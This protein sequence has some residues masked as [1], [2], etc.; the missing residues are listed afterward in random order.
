[1]TPASRAATHDDLAAAVETI[2]TSFHHDP[3]WAWA[4]PDPERRAGQYRV[5]WGLLLEGG[6][7]YDWVRVTERCESVAVWIPPGGTELAPEDEPRVAPL[8]TSL[9]DDHAPAV[10]EL[11]ERFEAAHPRDE[12]HYYL[13]LFGTHDDHRGKGLGMALLRENLALIDAEGMPAYLESTNPV[14]LERYRRVGFEPVGE[15]S[16]P[17]GGPTVTTMWREPR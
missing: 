9:L 17:G 14:N 7:R 15:F 12:P 5:W 1:V 3:L 10:V 8:L 4:F 16:A 6:I 11:V 13:S 2:T